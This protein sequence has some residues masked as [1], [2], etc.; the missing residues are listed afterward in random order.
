MSNVGM[1]KGYEATE[2]ENRTWKLFPPTLVNTAILINNVRTLLC[3]TDYC[4]M[5]YGL[6]P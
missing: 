2:M 4:F 3:F 5:R 6:G 1:M